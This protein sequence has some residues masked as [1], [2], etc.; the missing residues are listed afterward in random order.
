MTFAVVCYSPL[1]IDSLLS[2]YSRTLEPNRDSEFCYAFK[3]PQKN[4]SKVTVVFN[5]KGYCEKKNLQILDGNNEN[6][7]DV[8]KKLV[9]GLNA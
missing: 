8:V 9:E 7:I 3:Y 1:D 2:N 4:K 6:I 5:S